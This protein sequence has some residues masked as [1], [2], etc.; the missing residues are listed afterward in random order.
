MNVLIRAS[1]GRNVV[2]RPQARPA[3]YATTTLPPAIVEV[4]WRYYDEPPAAARLI[5]RYLPGQQVSVPFNPVVD[6]NVILSTISISAGGVRSVRSIRDAS[7]F[8]VVFQRETA[9]PT[10]TQIGASTNELIQLQIDNYLQFAIQRQVRTA[11]DPAMTAN[12]SVE[13]ITAQPG[14]ILPRVL[15]LMRP[16]P[17][18][19]ARTIYVRVSHS[20]GGAFGAESPAQAFT[21][22]DSGGGGGTTG[23]GDPTGGI[24]VECFSGQVRVKTVA[25]FV[26]FADLQLSGERLFMIENECGKHMATLI[27]HAARPRRMIDMGDDELVTLDHLMKSGPDSWAPA[28]KHFAKRPQVDYDG[29]VFSLHVFSPHARDQHYV[30]GN[31]EIAHNAKIA[32]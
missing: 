30:L 4:Y 12:L 22:T 2:I 1:G 31:G 3:F 14:Q 7:E 32:G 11:D 25:G 15:Y 8:A 26:S 17:G 10:V 20:S 28:A 13:T 18:T 9:A 24:G 27:T 29:Q 5:G 23:D 16:T 19:T 6:K 21:W